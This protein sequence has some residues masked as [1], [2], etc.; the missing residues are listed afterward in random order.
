VARAIYESESSELGL[1]RGASAFSPSLRKLEQEFE[2][3]RF[4]MQEERLKLLFAQSQSKRGLNFADA[5]RLLWIGGKAVIRR[6]TGPAPRLSS[7]RQ[8]V[9]GHQLPPRAFRIGRVHCSAVQAR[10]GRAANGFR[11]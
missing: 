6:C 9:H 3:I 7:Q 5:R 10:N 1:M 4:E 11:R 2:Q 8:A